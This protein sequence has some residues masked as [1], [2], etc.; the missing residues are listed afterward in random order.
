MRT[1]NSFQHFGKHATR[2]LPAV[3]VLL[4]LLL[5]PS[6]ARAQQV[7]PRK[8]G[9]DRQATRQWLR[10]QESRS[11]Q[12]ASYLQQDCPDFTNRRDAV[13]NGNK[14]TT[15]ISNFGSISAPGNTITDVVWNGLGYGYEF[16]PF[17]V[18]RVPVEDRQTGATHDT[19]IVSDGLTEQSGGEV[20]DTGDKFWSWQ[21]IPCAQP[22]GDFEGLRVV[23][24]NSNRI[25]TNDAPDRDRD[26]KPDSWPE[27]FYNA[28][29]GEYVW[30]GAL[31]QGASNAEKETLYFMNDY[32]NREFNYYPFPDDSSKRGLGLEVE[33][34]LYQWS[35]PL[36][37]NVIFLVY[38]I[39]N[40]S[41]KDLDDVTFG[42]WGDPHVGGAGDYSD[43]LA[44]FD[45]DI[46]MVYTWDD[47]GRSEV[48]GR[49][50]GYFGYKFLE[51]P[52]VGDTCIGAR[53]AT[54]AECEAAGGTFSPG[55]GIDNDGDGITDESWTDGID[56]DG[57]WDPETDDVGVDGV[58]GT[59][60]R[61][62]G[63]GE[64][65]GGSQFDIK[66][67][68]EPNFEF[69]DISESDMIGLTS[70]ASPTFGSEDISDDDGTSQL[71]EPGNFQSVPNDP[72]DY[73]FIYGSGKF[74][75]RAGATKRFSIALVLG[76]DRQDLTLNART[77]QS[78]YNA[79]YQFAKPPLRPTLTAVP[80][81][82]QVTLSWDDRAESSVDPLT[83]ESDF[84][85]YIIYRSTDPSFS[86]Q[87]TITDVRGNAFLH[88]PLENVNG[89]PAK[90]DLDNEYSGPSS[91]LYPD[92][93]VA[94]D[95]GD[96]TGLRHTFVD[97]NDV[98]NGQRYFYAVTAYDH[99]SEKT[100][101][102]QFENGIPPAETP[103]TITYNP[104]TDEY[105]FDR[106]T[107]S[108]I[109]RPRVAGY[110]PPSIEATGGLKHPEGTATGDIRLEI[111]NEM[112][113]RSD[114][115][116]R[117]IFE[118][119]NGDR[120]YSVVND[121][122]VQVGLAP[123]PGNFTSLQYS[124]ILPG[125]FQLSTQGGSTLNDDQYELNATDGVVK[126]ETSAPVERGDSLTAMFKYQPVYRAAN[127]NFEASQRSNL[128]FDGLQ[129][130]VD[131]EP[132][133]VNFDE[134]GWTQGN[135]SY[136]TV[137][138]PSASLTNLPR[139]PQPYDYEIRFGSGNVTESL[140]NGRPLPF[141]VVN[142]TRMNQEVKVYSPDDND[143]GS[144]EVDEEIVFVEQ[145]DGTQTATWQVNFAPNASP[146]PPTPQAGDVFFVRTNKPF[147]EQDVYSF[148][149]QA[150]Q[151]SSEEITDEL[152]DIYV[153]PNPY[154]A[155]NEI[156]PN[157]PT[158]RTER[159]KRR[160][161]F[162]NVPKTCTIRIYTLAG[163]LVEKIN[164]N[165]A[166]DDGKAFWDLRTKD[167]MNIAY[168]LYFYHVD[169]PA[170]TKTGKFA[171]IK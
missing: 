156:E 147:T 164:H 132:L 69:T 168:G 163:E 93:G 54:E 149:T 154:V 170:G 75:V 52:G 99:G 84:E 119:V 141:R 153:V 105:F 78:I 90:F 67:P 83:N 92:R 71:V 20:S 1:T 87:Q 144:W 127:F 45:D 151:T 51:S 12:P 74:A 106:N 57:D 18:A 23:N 40:K 64:P 137:R 152:D 143:N 61:G 125:S 116:Y 15:Q 115:P 91:I 126:V 63:D 134:T 37:E 171:V 22:V 62:E 139:E 109:P 46:N 122:P 161:Y 6:I 114:N 16:S 81:D 158:S 82:E 68:G 121:K 94:F 80:G 148:R 135:S 85:G 159:G 113:V 25:P 145:I 138:V 35:N 53:G 65:T 41:A 11:Y 38:K 89:V 107:A 123:V 110:V 120:T 39:T 108:V 133:A 96:N 112:D 13:M 103:K 157:N 4:A 8:R 59:G 33:T 155:H 140:S 29:I 48:A 31:S 95:L 44:S 124:H 42:M 98:V 131:N 5:A 79:D 26:G 21:P 150:A 111:T 72:G 27:D 2:R 136:D 56:N 160:I 162:A 166:L 55:D 60:D 88:E 36:A 142:L 76:E 66:K 73:V 47:D 32:Q 169:S 117:I 130:L 146:N 118:R 167:N 128:V 24:P 70:F 50:P 19:V 49:E 77:A 9:M 58:A 102:G 7:Q 34:R 10:A 86:D 101:G 165:S 43:D 3:A 30:P 17:V 97:S 14:I 100:L 129:L 104:T 28:T